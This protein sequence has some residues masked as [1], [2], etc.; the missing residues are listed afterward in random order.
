MLNISLC[1]E[2]TKEVQVFY[3]SCHCRLAY[4]AIHLEICVF[5]VYN[6]NK[7]ILLSCFVTVY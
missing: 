5:K 4:L 1:V 6:W 3:I 7:Y 2:T